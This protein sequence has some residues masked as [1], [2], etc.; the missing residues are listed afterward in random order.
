MKDSRLE[1]T[2]H[3]PSA[4]GSAPNGSA[5]NGS[6]N[7]R[8]GARG[9]TPHGASNIDAEVAALRREWATD[10]RWAGIDRTYGAADVVRLR[11]SV[12]EEA[13]LARLGAERLWT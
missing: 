4:N 9:T 12:Q 8:A 5:P 13:T 7:G 11:G 3:G 10:R 2:L 6:S 1:D